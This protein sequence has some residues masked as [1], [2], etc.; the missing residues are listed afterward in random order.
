MNVTLPEYARD[1]LRTGLRLL[2]SPVVFRRNKSAPD[3]CVINHNRCICV[4]KT[5]F[6]RLMPKAP[7][8]QV[9]AM[10]CPAHTRSHLIHDST[11]DS[12]KKT[13]SFLTGKRDLAPDLESALRLK[14]V[15]DY[16][17]RSRCHQQCK[18][19][20]Y[21]KSSRRTEPCPNRH[22]T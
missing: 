7:A 13:L 6:H 9:D 5:Q 10:A 14:G 2:P 16:R 18:R 19:R 15:Q 22:I 11:T 3:T 20:G 12:D 1:H 4:V 21:F 8:I 17:V